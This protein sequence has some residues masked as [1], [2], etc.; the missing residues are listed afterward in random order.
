MPVKLIPCAPAVNES[1]RK[2][3]EYLKQQL[4]A[5]AKTAEW[6]LLTNLDFSSS[7]NRQSDEIDILAVGPPGVQIVEVKHWS[8]S[9]VER[10]VELV[11]R[12]A[13][14]ISYKARKVGTTLRRIIKNLPRVEAV[15]FLTESASKVAN[16]DQIGRIRGV[17]FYTFKSWDSAVGIYATPVLSTHDI[18]KIIS[19][20]NPRGTIAI[21][22]IPRRFAGF[23]HLE[24]T[25]PKSNCFH[26]IFKATHISRQDRVE[27]HIYDLSAA[28]KNALAKAEREWKSLHRLQRYTWAPRIVD[29]FQDEPRN[30]GEIKFFT[31]ADSQAP[32]I[33]ERKDDET[34]LLADRLDFVYQTA[35][36]L[37]ELHTEGGRDEPM[38]HRNITNRS[39]LVNHDNSPILTGFEY[40]R[41]PT[42]ISIASTFINKKWDSAVAPEVKSQ[43]L[44]AADHRSDIYS[45]CTSLLCLFETQNDDL[46]TE[47]VDVLELGTI[48]QPESRITLNDLI[49]LLADLLGER[50]TGPGIPVD[51][52]PAR[53][54]T[55]NQK[56]RFRD[57][58]YRIVTRLGSGGVGIAFK[59]VKIDPQTKSDLGT[60]V[61]KV[62][63]DEDTGNRIL[64]SYLKAHPHL[65]HSSLSI[66]FEVAPEWQEN[67]FLALMTWIDGEPLE[68]YS[69]R[70]S[71]L[72]DEL[73]EESNET[74]ALRWLRSA[75]LG[76]KALHDNGL[77]HGDISPT[78]MIVNGSDL[79]LTDYDNVTPLGTKFDSP[80]TVAY[81]SPSFEFGLN[82]TPS[83]D[84]FALSASFFK[85][86]FD[87]NPFQYGGNI[88]KTKGLNWS[89]IDSSEYVD[90]ANFLNKA[91]SP[92]SEERFNNVV[93]ALTNLDSYKPS[94]ETIFEDEHTERNKN[95]VRWLKSVLKSYPGSLYGNSETRGLDTDFAASTYVETILEKSL[96]KAINERTVSLVVLCGNAG[97]GKTA[98]LQRIGREMKLGDFSSSERFIKQKLNSEVTVFMN[99]DGSASYKQKSADNLLDEFFEP[100]H[101]EY[102]RTDIIHLLAINDGR[103]LE[104]I[105]NYEERNETSRLT[106]DLRKALEGSLDELPTDVKFVNLNQRSLVGG[107]N[108]ETN[109]IDNSFLHQLVDK[110]YGGEN[111]EKIWKPCQTCSAQHRCH[112]FQAL[113]RFGPKS[114]SDKSHRQR[115]RQRLFEALQAIHLR[116]DVHIT[117]RELRSALVY[118]LFGLHYCH[119][120]HDAEHN[121]L[122]EFFPYWDRSFSP[123]SF[124]RQGDV[125]RELCY[126]DPALDSHSKIDRLL[127]YPTSELLTSDVARSYEN[128]SLNSR[129]RKA[130][131]EW[132]LE[133]VKRVTDNPH[134]LGLAQGQ[135]LSE[136]LNLAVEQD[137]KKITEL[138]NRLCGGIARLETLPLRV[139]A[140]TKN[141]PLKLTPRTPTDTD[142]WVEK[143]IENF[144]LSAD[145]PK[146][147]KEID[148]L[149][150]YVNLVYKSSD[151]EVTLQIGARLFHFLLDLN[152]G[153]QLGDIAT[154]DIFANLS[155]FVQRLIREDYRKL[156][157][158]NPIKE[159]AVFEITAKKPNDGDYT[160][161]QPI[162]MSQAY[163]L[164][165]RNSNGD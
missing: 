14:R 108:E 101:K 162:S 77:V 116:G 127:L 90:L 148:R 21:D 25:S 129:R 140:K 128:L 17:P 13:D 105:T 149:H 63:R 103:L 59:V 163:R 76:L 37:F 73:Q 31:V 2:A 144:H 89:D 96:I 160:V 71:H 150:R 51:A 87:R 142:F 41:I 114:L 67:N 65:R 75:C 106:E 154:D 98:L 1:E 151:I 50:T 79:V 58:D 7:H 115:S 118:I 9:W 34:W 40:A 94:I 155:I 55:E 18:K 70:F 43:G 30:I 95:E 15:F 62:A 12:E 126:L 93:D 52:P 24:L 35:R 88:E 99:F 124:G 104:W 83:D 133:T 130:Y 61:A 27:L 131:F 158:W 121:E 22:G 66:I 42:D 20:L 33:Q 8:T 11:E 4:I 54:W 74:L 152:D 78:N 3:F 161:H 32:S 137:E 134:T 38:V 45:L 84:I 47:I 92:N 138:K 49:D 39:I 16:I 111:S 86:L 165:D 29:S 19:S 46:S 60:Y 102:G 28:S 122:Q 72:T 147:V 107:V 153:Y 53:Y 125:L 56:I 136:F 57:Q 64:S 110:L 159:N 120:Y 10:N 112:V 145:L 97:D 146:Q 85:V 132:S 100:F 119:D 123:E 6:F 80:G 44:S 113:S 26:R 81:C 164:E 48:K 143:D 156:Y 36:A 82:A 135:H 91:T 139:F 68:E 23:S 109:R 157:A 69:G 141:V 117:I 5:S